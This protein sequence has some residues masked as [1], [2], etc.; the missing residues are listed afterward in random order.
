MVTLYHNPRCS[1]SREALALLTAR[2]IEPEIVEYLKTPPD[3]DEVQRL[4]QK[5]GLTSVRQ[6]LRSGEEI[7]Q[8]RQL[9][10]ASEEQ[11][12]E[13]LCAYPQLLQRPIVING[14]RGCIAR[15]AERALTLF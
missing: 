4:M 14:D 11:L 6:L 1:K 5:L 2:G 12:I 3:G 15:P 9:A 10:D 8:Q 13:A 7:Y